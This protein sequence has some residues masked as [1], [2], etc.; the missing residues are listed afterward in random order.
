MI[1]GQGLGNVKLEELLVEETWLEKLAGEFHKPQ[2]KNLF[3]FVQ[4]EIQGSG[5]PIYPPQHLIFNALNT[6]PFDRV[7]VV[8]IGQV[9]FTRT[10]AYHF[11]CF[12]IILTVKFRR[13]CFKIAGCIPIERFI[14]KGGKLDHW[15]QCRR[16]SQFFSF[17]F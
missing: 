12:C 8:I 14:R 15:Q 2:V 11:L 3:T 10:W 17:S 1:I 6:T 16:K 7:K 9:N 4:S 13:F 5:V